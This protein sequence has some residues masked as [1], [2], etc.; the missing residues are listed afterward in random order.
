MAIHFENGYFQKQIFVVWWKQQKKYHLVK[1]DTVCTEK[2]KGGLGILNLRWINISL[3]TKWLWKLEREEGLWQ[4]IVRKKYM[5]GK[6]LCVLK[7]QGD[8][9]F[10]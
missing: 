3:L 7:K 10:W 6:P 5:K 4:T 9:Q 2:N 8:S 1:W